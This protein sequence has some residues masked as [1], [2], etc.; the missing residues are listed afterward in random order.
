[1]YLNERPSAQD[2]PSAASTPERKPV[3]APS[4]AEAQVQVWLHPLPRVT[5]FPQATAA[6]REGCSQVE[7]TD[8][9]VARAEAHMYGTE[10]P[11][12]EYW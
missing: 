2:P 12:I 11:D 3:S 1:M 9:A 5:P 4:Q 6:M 7:E 10:E 8:T